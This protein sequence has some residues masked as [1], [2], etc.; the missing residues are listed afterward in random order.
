MADWMVE[1]EAVITRSARH[2]C[3]TPITSNVDKFGAEF[4]RQ[5]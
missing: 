3:A 5:E 2:S 4:L 1:V